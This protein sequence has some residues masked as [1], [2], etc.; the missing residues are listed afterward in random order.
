MSRWVVFDQATA[1]AVPP[2]AGSSLELHHDPQM[3]P[4]SVVALA[5]GATGS[6]VALVPAAD[7]EHT[8]VMRF[9]RHSRPQPAAKP[10]QSATRTAP[11]GFLGLSDELVLDDQPEPPKNW[12]QK[13]LD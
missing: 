7:G 2:P 10:Q 11:A 9:L 12:W 4:A 6:S 13:L 8:L 3:Q 1:D 5:M